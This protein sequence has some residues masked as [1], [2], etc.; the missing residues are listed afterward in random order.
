MWRSRGA[1]IGIAVAL[2]AAAV[3]SARAA[4]RAQAARLSSADGRRLLDVPFLPQSEDLCGGAAVAMVL[5]Y[6]GAR[7]VH[8]DDF[9]ALVDRSRAGIPADVLTGD[10]RRRGWQAL[11]F[12]A[13]EADGGGWAG[14]HVD[15]GRPVVALIAVGPARYHYVVIVATT[16]DA[17]VVHDP[18]SAPFRVLPRHE[19][20]AAWAATGR[21][22]LLILPVPTTGDVAPPVAA[23]PAA[24][25]AAS[26]TSDAGIGTPAPN[27]CSPLVREMVG[28]AQAGDLNGAASGLATA[29][30][31]CPHAAEAWRELAGVRFRQSRWTDAVSL[32]ARAA[33]LEPT[34]V[35]GWDLLATS[36]FLDGRPRDALA[37]WARIGRPQVDVVRVT[38]ARR[39]RHPVIAGAVNLAPRS[40]LTRE[41]FDHATRRLEALP[42]TAMSAL[43][44]QPTA[45]GRADVEAVIVERPLA[46]RGVLPAVAAL[47]RLG[48]HREARLALASP[49]GSGELWSAAWRWWENRP[50]V[51]FALAL[52]AAGELPGIT[53]V[54][55]L[56]ERASYSVATG[57]DGPLVVRQE[58]RRAAVH[59]TDWATSRLRWRAGAALDRWV[60]DAFASVDTALEMRLHGELVALGTEVAGWASPG[61]RRFGRTAMS[62]TA[63]GHADPGRAGV[64][65]AAGLSQ[66]TADAP[67]DLWDGAGLGRART[68]LLRAHP[69]LEGGV[70]AGP[71]F[72]RRLAHATLEYQQPLATMA[73]GAVSVALFTDA[74]RAWQRATAG[75]GWHVDSGLGLR[76]ALPGTAGTLRVDVARGL[77]DATHV[78]SAGWSPA[79]P[80]R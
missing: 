5:R 61:G 37:S 45:G 69:L 7:D 59:V 39:T 24:V 15:A 28:R 50:R 51:S 31:L 21:W 62:L 8:P 33:A 70:V 22:A 35:D 46:P 75:A 78:L 12:L 1:A 43:R 17:V 6:W 76:V 80:S 64:Q 29:T 74:A 9:A 23:V 14:G 53:T 77:R 48:I 16:A 26:R 38:G 13:D 40:L 20:D 65:L 30:A 11:P 3:T 63:R 32:A 79:W 60:D 68:P 4:P 34:D 36:Q 25:G 18:A 54:E 41:T 66:V 27:A 71:L 56:W 2:L 44:Y 42:A 55:A 52:P 57:V 49:T 67:F 58:R 73:G 19:F 47:V 72:G 10:V